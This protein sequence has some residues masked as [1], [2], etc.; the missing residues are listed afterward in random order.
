MVDFLSTA[1]LIFLSFQAFSAGS[2]NCFM[3]YQRKSIKPEFQQRVTTSSNA[4]ECM[5]KCYCN[6]HCLTSFTYRRKVCAISYFSA[7]LYWVRDHLLNKKRGKQPGVFIPM[8]YVST[9]GKDLPKPVG[10]WVMDNSFNGTNL[11]SY[12]NLLDM[13]VGGLKWKMN[14]PH[15]SRTPLKYAHFDGCS[16]P[17]INNRH[18]GSYA[19]NFKKPFSIGFWVKTDEVVGRMP[20][21]DGWNTENN[22]AA[23]QFGFHPS[24]YQQQFASHTS[25]YSTT[26]F[27]KGNNLHSLEWRH[28][29]VVYDGS[30]VTHY[31]NATE[32][33][34][35]DSLEGWLHQI[36]PDV[37]NIGHR[38]SEKLYFRGALACLSFFDVSLS[39]AEVRS[40]MKVC[41]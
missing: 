29:A 37:I 14:G 20:V 10:M 23:A 36:N 6:P 35:S 34:Q 19:L 12:G 22:T 16:L 40:L 31:L 18:K 4:M 41:P 2:K 39:Q 3:H 17:K 30:Q 9:K 15:G 26:T 24:L 27:M 38:Q 8:K 11:G 7:P 33:H 32:W 13:S 5:K 21:I 1:L 28:I 25:R